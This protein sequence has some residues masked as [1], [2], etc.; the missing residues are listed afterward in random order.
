MVSPFLISPDWYRALMPSFIL[1]CTC[2]QI[3]ISEEQ[4]KC[5]LSLSGWKMI[6]FFPWGL[7]TELDTCM[8]AD[9]PRAQQLKIKTLVLSHSV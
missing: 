8:L 3:Q 4:V 7:L 5:W 9:D 2:A 1:D 6:H